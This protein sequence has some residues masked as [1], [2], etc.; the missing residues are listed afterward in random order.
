MYYSWNPH[1]SFGYHQPTEFGTWTFKGTTAGL[2]KDEESLV[3]IYP[4]PAIDVAYL[5]EE[6]ESVEVFNLFGESVMSSQNIDKIDVSELESGVY[7]V[8]V[9]N[10][11]IVTS[12]K[13]V[14]N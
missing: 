10:N 2:D 3:K 14:I 4:N 12:Q 7:S 1:G 5:S 13:I 11:G 6:V 9:N 8:S